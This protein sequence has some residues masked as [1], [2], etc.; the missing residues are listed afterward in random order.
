MKKL[1]L[2]LPVVVLICGLHTT[3]YSAARKVLVEIQTST[4]CAPCYAADVFYF[5]NWLP[6]YGGNSL[7][8]TLAY[9]VWWPS[10]GNDPM[11]LVNPTPVQTRVSYYTPSGPIY[12]PWAWIDGFITGGSGYSSWPGAIEGRF[13]DPSPVS[14]TLTGNRNGNTLNLN[15]AIFADRAVN[16]SNWRVHWVVVESGISQPQNSGSGYVP[17]VHDH[18][19]RNMYPDANGSPITI[20]QGQTVNIPRVITLNST[21]V[22][23]N[24][25]VI[26]FVQNNTDKK[27]QNVEYKEVSD[28][29]TGVGEPVNGVPTTFG[30]SQNYPNPFNP[31]TELDYAV[32]QQSFVSIKV[33]NLLGQEVRTLVSEDKGVG[34]YKATWDGK[35]YIGREVPSG[36]YMYTMIAGSFTDTRKMMFLK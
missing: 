22:A 10:P 15:A 36:M 7:V 9:H 32:S 35:D 1:S 25:R 13:L 19:H 29:P 12:A 11:F 34:T 8:V 28:I 33:F 31:S 21:W 2:L 4:T 14:I 18:A 23:A 6:N 27:V 3:G 5:Q 26:V 20:S 16:S 30:I 24:C 17:F